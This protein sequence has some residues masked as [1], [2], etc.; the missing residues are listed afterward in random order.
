MSSEIPLGIT[1]DAMGRVVCRAFARGL[2]NGDANIIESMAK[3]LDV[4]ADGADP[5]S[6][7]LTERPHT[8]GFRDVEIVSL[9]S[10]VKWVCE[11]DDLREE[12]GLPKSLT[13]GEIFR[14]VAQLFKL[15]PAN[16][17]KIWQRSSADALP[18]EEAME[19]FMG[20][21]L[22]ADMRGRV[23]LHRAAQGWRVRGRL[24]RLVSG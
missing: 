15:E 17:K 6:I 5:R 7:L 10:L 1:N 8:F 20:T 11:H 21:T 9:I 22:C 23:A 24:Q 4:I 13:Q 12:T 18:I 2:R 3:A 14:A 16:V 19:V